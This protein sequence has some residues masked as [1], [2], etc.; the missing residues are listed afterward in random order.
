MKKK[1]M[2][3]QQKGKTYQKIWMKN[4]SKKKEIY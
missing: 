4:Y 2:R 1:K 3:Y